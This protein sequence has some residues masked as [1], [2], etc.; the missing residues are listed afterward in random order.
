MGIIV[1]WDY[2]THLTTKSNLCPT[3]RVFQ[4]DLEMLLLLRDVI[5]DDVN[6]YL[7]LTVP[8]SKVQLPKTSLNKRQ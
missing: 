4:A 6:C 8:R 2:D 5:I 7:Q 3:L 1:G